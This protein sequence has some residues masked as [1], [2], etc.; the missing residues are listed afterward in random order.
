MK[1]FA[2]TLL[3]AL[4]AAAAHMATPTHAQGDPFIDE[5]MRKAN[6]AEPDDGFCRRAPWPT[7]DSQGEHMFLER[8]DPGSA[9]AAKFA[10]GAC[11]YTRITDVYRGQNGRC[12]R[13]TWWACQPGKTCNLGESHFCKGPDGRYRRQ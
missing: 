1:V 11:S 5:I 8:A 7:T 9:E 10:S 2:T 4:A 3:V 6:A 12:V 13:Y